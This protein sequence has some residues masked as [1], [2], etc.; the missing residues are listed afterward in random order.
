MNL[1]HLT[2]KALLLDTKNLALKERELTT[3][4]LHHLKEIE[5]RKLYSDLKYGSLHEYC[6]KELGYCSGSAHRRVVASR[7]L[8]EIPSIEIK[9][10]NGVLNLSNIAKAATF[11]KENEVTSLKDKKEILQQVENLST[12]DC[13]KK[14]QSLLSLNEIKTIRISLLE[15]TVQE[16]NKI[17]SLIGKNL[18]NDQLIL[19][20]VDISE[21]KIEKS[22]FK[23]NPKVTVTPAPGKSRVI[24]AGVKRA[25]YKRDEKKCVQCGSIH[26]LN[27]DH[28]LPFALGGKSTKE[29]IRLL[30]FNCNQRARIKAR[31]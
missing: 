11:F 9:I 26:N 30:C 5:S 23:Q 2:D 22:K 21:V 8:K 31:L 3:Q 16:M 27:F 7:L 19:T 20:M 10:E 4:V 28:R 15:S 24:S 25:V 14:L 18:S 12:R 17:K 6:V 1:R 13:E 29:N